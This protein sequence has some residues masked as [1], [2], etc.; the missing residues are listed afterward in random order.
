MLNIL[1]NQLIAY[2]YTE[3]EKT[4]LLDWLEGREPSLKAVPLDTTR[5]WNIGRK[6]FTLLKLTVLQK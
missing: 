6:V 4:I 2:A 5:K 3:A 1:I